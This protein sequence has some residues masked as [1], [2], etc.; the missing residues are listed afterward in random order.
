MAWEW[1]APVGTSVV[2]IAGIAAAYFSGRRQTRTE[3]EVA[4]DQAAA[5]LRAM[6]EERQQRRIEAAY[7]MLLDVVAEGSAWL[8]RVDT[9]ALGGTDDLRP[10]AQPEAVASLVQRGSLTSVW[11]P[12]VAQLAREWTVAVGSA[13][14]AAR[15]LGY[16]WEDQEDQ[17]IPNRN[18]P[19]GLDLEDVAEGRV[20]QVDYL[21]QRFAT[22]SRKAIGVESRIRDQVWR[23]L[24]GDDGGYSVE[25]S[26]ASASGG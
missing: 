20:T 23:E 21:Y 3:R 8:W 19:A 6:R 14:S 1:V 10:P 2:G 25:H 24:R 7:P 12:H 17:V 13:W 4:A 26:Q 9:F 16:L 22:S 15:R 11:S 5:T 18:V